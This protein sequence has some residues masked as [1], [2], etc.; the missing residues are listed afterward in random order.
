M[1]IDGPYSGCYDLLSHTTACGLSCE[2]IVNCLN[3]DQ[4][5]VNGQCVD[6]DPE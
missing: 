5:C 2:T 1:E 3:T 4:Q 6:P